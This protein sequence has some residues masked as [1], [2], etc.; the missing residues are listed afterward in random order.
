MLEECDLCHNTIRIS[1]AYFTGTQILCAKCCG[2]ENDIT[3][4]EERFDILTTDSG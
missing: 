3:K 1:E 2:G 4:E